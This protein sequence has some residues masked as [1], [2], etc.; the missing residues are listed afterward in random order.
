MSWSWVATLYVC[1]G[2]FAFALF[3]DSVLS[4]TMEL[5]PISSAFWLWVFLR[6]FSSSL[7]A[8]T[9]VRLS[10]A[11]FS[12]SLV[13]NF[14]LVVS[15]SA[16]KLKSLLHFEFHWVGVWEISTLHIR[17]IPGHMYPIRLPICFSDGIVSQE[18]PDVGVKLS[19]PTRNFGTSV[20]YC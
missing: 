17:F 13:V 3:S 7:V 18:M 5:N 1:L 2:E 8:F 14:L 11:L 16:F 4:K 6:F 19:A 10:L 9:A 12:N 15:P 20:E